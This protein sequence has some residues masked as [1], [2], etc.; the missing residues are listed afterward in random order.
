MF[1]RECAAPNPENA[2]KW[3][4]FV[5]QKKIG[6]DMFKKSGWASTTAGAPGVDYASKLVWAKNPEDY[7]KR[8]ALW[9][10][11]KAGQ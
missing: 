3:I 1:C 6:E 2:Y 5:Y 4:N 8:Q 11:V 10:E 9:N 7:A